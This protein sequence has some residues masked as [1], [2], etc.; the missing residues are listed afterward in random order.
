MISFASFGSFV[1]ELQR[2]G[3]NETKGMLDIIGLLEFIASDNNRAYAR[4]RKSCVGFF[5]RVQAGGEKYG[6]PFILN[7]NYV[8]RPTRN[9]DVRDLFH[10]TALA[11]TNVPI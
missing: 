7:V 10:Y 11:A 4:G 9:E 5:S 8:T 2:R 3:E 1:F 6:L